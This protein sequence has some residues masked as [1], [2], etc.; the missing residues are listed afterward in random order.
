[1]CSQPV[2][3]YQGEESAREVLY[4]EEL[5]CRQIQENGR[6]D[7]EKLETGMY[8][9]KLVFYVQSTGTV[10]SELIYFNDMYFLK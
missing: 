8:V 5:R 9:S 6:L 10:I 4:K 7:R 2:R 3:V 1:M